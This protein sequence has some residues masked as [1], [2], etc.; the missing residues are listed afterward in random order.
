M[1]QK[2]Q[3]PGAY[4]LPSSTIIVPDSMYQD[5]K[6]KQ[7]LIDNFVVKVNEYCLRIYGKKDGEVLASKIKQLITEK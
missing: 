4:Q 1:Y 2:G 6:E 5:L 3:I 7:E